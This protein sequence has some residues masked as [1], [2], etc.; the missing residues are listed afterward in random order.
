MPYGGPPMT[1]IMKASEFKAKCLAVMDE[2]AATGE[3][4]VVTKN[5]KPVVDLVPHKKKTKR[6]LIGLFK[7]DLVIKGDIISPIDVEWDA[8]K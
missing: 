2:V 6:N 1:K 8:M 5:G 4:V 3:G 7:N